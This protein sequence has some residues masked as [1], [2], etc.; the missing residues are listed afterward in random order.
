MDTGTDAAQTASS[1]REASEMCE[2]EGL[3]CPGRSCGCECMNCLMGDN[4]DGL[5][6]PQTVG[7][8]CVYWTEE[9]AVICGHSSCYT[10]VREDDHDCPIQ[11]F[12]DDPITQAYGLDGDWDEWS[13]VIH[14]PICYRMEFQ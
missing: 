5:D 13:R 2:H 3:P 12:F 14:C 9:D 11:Q 1:Q 10:I 6:E 7:P 8:L 4:D